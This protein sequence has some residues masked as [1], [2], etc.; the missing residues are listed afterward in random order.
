MGELKYIDAAGY[1]AGYLQ[2]LADNNIEPDLEG[3]T[4]LTLD[5]IGE[6]SD[7]EYALGEIR[8]LI[9]QSISNDD[10]TEILTNKD[11]K[12]KLGQLIMLIDTDDMRLGQVVYDLEEDIAFGQEECDCAG[13]PDCYDDIIPDDADECDQMDCLNEYIDDHPERFSA[14]NIDYNGY[15]TMVKFINTIDD[16]KLYNRLSDAI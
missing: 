7:D 13:I 1:V 5:Y 12:I 8:L 3:I 2:A 14:V 16:D 10:K 9:D 11:I 4:K 6:D 15:D